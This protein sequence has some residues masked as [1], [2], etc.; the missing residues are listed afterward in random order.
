MLKEE[1]GGDPQ[2]R[3]NL[4]KDITQSI[5]QIP[6]QITRQVYIK[7]TADKLQIN[8]QLL[9]REVIRLRQTKASEAHKQQEEK[10]RLETFVRMDEQAAENRNSDETEANSTPH[11]LP[12]DLTRTTAICCK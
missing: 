7:D 9:T 6:D 2:K 5:A 3:A 1:A 4:I 8:E 12:A 10:E 11:A